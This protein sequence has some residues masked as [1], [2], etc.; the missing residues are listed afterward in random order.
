MGATQ[1]TS[2]YKIGGPE[3]VGVAPHSTIKSPPLLSPRT[4]CFSVSFV[5]PNLSSHGT[6]TLAPL[7]AALISHAE[8][9]GLS[10]SLAQS[11]PLPT[12]SL[13]TSATWALAPPHECLASAPGSL[14]REIALPPHQG[15]WPPHRRRQ[16]VV[17]GPAAACSSPFDPVE[18]TR[19]S[20]FSA[21]NCL[22]PSR[23]QSG[24]QICCRQVT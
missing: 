3:I 7:H 11:D 24:P 10:T 12:S 16:L 5:Y 20:F 21:E 2:P 8:L 9:S 18:A 4:Q 13:H 22:L 15:V 14:A 1:A 17:D 6:K 19:S 23:R